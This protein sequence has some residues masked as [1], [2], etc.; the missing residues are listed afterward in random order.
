MNFCE[1]IEVT[2]ALEDGLPTVG[3][4]NAQVVVT[5]VDAIDE[6]FHFTPR[7]KSEVQ[8]IENFENKLLA[9]AADL[10]P[11]LAAVVSGADFSNFIKRG[12]VGI[13]K[14]MEKEFFETTI[15]LDQGRDGMENPL[16]KSL[17]KGFFSAP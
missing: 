4:N 9:V 16:N 11:D 8:A 6:S 5:S 10:V 2:D 1:F 12:V 15:P 17:K 7:G 13:P 14:K 3:T